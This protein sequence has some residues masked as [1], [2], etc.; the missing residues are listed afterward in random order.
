M[1]V[2]VHLTA[3]GIARFH[4]PSAEWE[5]AKW[6]EEH[7]ARR[8]AGPEAAVEVDTPRALDIL[9]LLGQ[10]AQESTREIGRR[11]GMTR[12]TTSRHLNTMAKRGHVAIVGETWKTG[13]I[14]ARTEAGKGVIE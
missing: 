5:A 14:W 9:A 8:E 3:V 1:I 12:P 10:V 11:L 2:T 7:E 4:G 13:K 6:I